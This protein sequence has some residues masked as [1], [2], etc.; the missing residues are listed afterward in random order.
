MTKVGAFAAKTHFSELLDRVE[1]GE[2]ILIERRGKTIA[3]LA[4]PARPARQS[5]PELVRELEE[6]RKRHPVPEG[7]IQS[8]ID[9]GRGL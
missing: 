1:Q 5:W 8:A 7:S 9:E 2:R 6:I 4:P 3:E